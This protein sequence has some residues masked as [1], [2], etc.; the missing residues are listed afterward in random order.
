M[1]MPRDHVIAVFFIVRRERA[2]ALLRNQS[3]IQGSR[4]ASYERASAF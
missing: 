2:L 4:W 1:V 3:S